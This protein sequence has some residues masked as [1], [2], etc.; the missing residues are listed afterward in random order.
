MV[1]AGPVRVVVRR[2]GQPEDIA[3]A[4]VY[5]VREEAGYIT[6]QIIGINGGRTIG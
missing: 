3:A 1:V 2:V 6:G 5:L 4:C